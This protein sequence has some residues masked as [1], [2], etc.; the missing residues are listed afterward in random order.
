MRRIIFLSLGML[1][2]LSAAVLVHFAWQLP[3]NAEVEDTMGRAERVTQRTGV[4]VQ[5]LR[6]QVRVLRER[7]PQMQALAQRLQEEMRVINDQL[8]TQ[9][10]DYNTVQTLSDCAG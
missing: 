1:E 10:I 4:Q 8:K 3:G 6:D 9:K 5:R 7:R 2:L